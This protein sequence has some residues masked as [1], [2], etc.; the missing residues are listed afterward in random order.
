MVTAIIH[1]VAVILI[2]VAPRLPFMRELEAKRQQALE[3]QR[4]RELQHEKENRQFVFVQPRVDLQAKK[5]PPRADLSDI[6]RQARTTERAPKP[7]NPLPF[8]RGNTSERIEAAAPAEARR[9][10]PPQPEPA[11][12]QPDPSRDVHAAG[13]PERAAGAAEQRTAEAAAGSSRRGHC[14]RDPQRAEVRTERQLRQS[15]GR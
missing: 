6:D 3:E 9:T 1:L 12:P 15:A 5:P 7:T 13:R 4:L 2:L 10:A 11:Q 8:A 14:R